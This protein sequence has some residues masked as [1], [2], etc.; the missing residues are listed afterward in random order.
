MKRKGTK[1]KERKEVGKGEGKSEGKGKEGEGKGKVRR[2]KKKRMKGNGRIN[3]IER[4]YIRP[5]ISSQSQGQRTTQVF[6][7]PFLSS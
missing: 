2:G 3:R 6:D 1:L 4:K 5:A 7:R